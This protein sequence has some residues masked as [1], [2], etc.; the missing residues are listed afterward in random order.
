MKD[1]GQA[2]LSHATRRKEPIRRLRRIIILA[3]DRVSTKTLRLK[4][5]GQEQV[6]CD[7]GAERG[8]KWLSQQREEGGQMI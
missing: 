2:R 7:G 6:Y 1:L 3:E 4:W 8:V 5:P